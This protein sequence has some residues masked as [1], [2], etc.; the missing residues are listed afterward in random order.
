MYQDILYNAHGTLNWIIFALCIV[1]RSFYFEPG[2]LVLTLLFHAMNI[3][4][5]FGIKKL[6][7]LN[8]VINVFIITV[9]TRKSFARHHLSHGFKLTTQRQR[10]RFMVINSKAKSKPPMPA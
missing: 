7:M 8:V 10:Q 4:H 9:C 6:S 3:F 1:L 2:R 5:T